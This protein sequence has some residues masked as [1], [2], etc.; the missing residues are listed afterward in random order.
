[1]EPYMHKNFYS[2]PV[3]TVNPSPTRK[4]GSRRLQHVR[5]YWANSCFL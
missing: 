4:P 5:S 3:A 1:M 2:L